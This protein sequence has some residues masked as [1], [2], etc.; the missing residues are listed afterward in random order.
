MEMDK[1]TT[2][3]DLIEYTGCRFPQLIAIRHGSDSISFHQ[4]WDHV[5]RLSW[6]F[7]N[8]CGI[9]K[10]DRVVIF[11][12]NQPEYL[13]TYF[14]L[15]RIGAIAVPMNLSLTPQENLVIVRNVEPSA[16][17]ASSMTLEKVHL[18]L[19]KVPS[20]R[21]TILVE[22]GIDDR[23]PNFESLL[24][25]KP[26]MDTDIDLS[27]RDIASCHYT[28]GTTGRPKGILLSHGNLISNVRSL[29]TTRDW[30]L[31]HHVFG[32]PLPL[33]H[34]YSTTILTLFPLSIGATVVLMP[35]FTPEGCLSTIVDYGITF[36]GGVPSMYALFNKVK[37]PSRFDI[38]RCQ[39]W[40]CGGAPLPMPVLQEFETRFKATLYEGY[41]LIETSPVVTLNPLDYR[42]KPG[43]IGVPV[44]DVVVKIIDDEGREVPPGETGE[45]IV[46]GPN[47]M[48]GYFRDT[49]RTGEVIKNGWF[50]TGDLGKVD[51]DGFCSIV[52]RK[53]E[54]IIVGGENVYPQEIDEVL[55]QLDGVADAAAVGIE[56]PVRGERVKAF[57]VRKDGDP[58]S[59]DMI[60]DHCR[61]RLASYKV[62]R[63]LEFCDQIPRNAT[64]KILRW[65]LARNVNG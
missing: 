25:E 51:K 42:R 45:V 12:P 11:I 27:E 58:L 52:G 64:G 1:V 38:S 19:D 23:Y 4:L 40:I 44:R 21:I 47:I 62:P 33:F 49:E 17:I 46:Q 48:Q 29:Q 35:R 39:Y 26:I 13:Y 53:K 31:G 43:T 7:H 10:G 2:V 16:I 9:K 32:C 14:A 36:F 41:G 28:S 54:L 34:G 63:E 56:D 50:Y 22:S 60:L 15:L 61:E 8:I 3:R 20:V 5:N 18:I 59:K 55:L 65:K 37:N 30:E 57:I 24:K 6:S